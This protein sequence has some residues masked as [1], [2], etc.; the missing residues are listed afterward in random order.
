[1]TFAEDEPEWDEEAADAMVGAVVLIGIT[2][3]RAEG[4]EQTQMHGVIQSADPHNGV[5]IILS[6]QREGETY[7]LPPDLGAFEPAAP[8]EY[9]LRSTGEVVVDPDF[10]TSWTVEAPPN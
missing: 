7:R 1:M 5:E 6:G 2:V 9:R 4:D 3:R 8:G 10:V